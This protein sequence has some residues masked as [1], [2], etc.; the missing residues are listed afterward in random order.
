MNTPAPSPPVDP[1]DYEFDLPEDAI[2]THPATERD[3]SRLLVLDRA[4]EG[5]AHRHF[6][7]LPGYLRPG[8]ALVLNETR[9]RPARILG[10]RES[11]GRVEFLVLN[12]HPSGGWE[13]MAKPARRL[14]P[15]EEVR[16]DG[17]VA[18]VLEELDDGR[19]RIETRDGGGAVI[20]PY[21]LGVP[22]L[23]PYIR[24]VPEEEDRERYQT[25]FAREDGAVAAPTA[26]LHFT[27]ALLE[28]IA[29]MGVHL[30]RVLLHVGPG[31][32]LTVGEEAIAAGRLHREWFRYPREAADRLN[33]VRAG[34]G[35]VIAVGTTSARVLESVGRDA[36]EQEG[37]TD[38]FIRPPHV[39]TAIDG[40]V[41]NFHL[42]RSSLIMLV[43]AMVGR[44]RVLAAYET[45]R[46]AGYRF[47]SYGD[48]MLIL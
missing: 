13:A 32:F 47:Y 23:P 29:G 41:T 19:R 37:W 9:V 45:A 36:D 8:D 33:Q 20:D 44:E 21:T 3:A 4:G 17:G 40:M 30:V 39:F 34:G 7:D 46:D 31:T 1:A 48:A 26:G 22:A 12:P 11:G 27:P 16:C 24:R 25:V 6:R 42:P 15:G 10:H 14:R 38:L 5:I 18:R 35:R 43:A 2:A 28:S